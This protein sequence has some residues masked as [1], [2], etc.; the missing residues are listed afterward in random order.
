MKKVI[1]ILMLFLITATTFSQTRFG[2]GIKLYNASEITDFRYNY[3]LIPV[4]RTDGFLNRYIHSDSLVLKSD[5]LDLRKTYEAGDGITIINDTINNDNYFQFFQKN[6]PSPAFGSVEFGIGTTGNESTIGISRTIGGLPRFNLK[7]ITVINGVNTENLIL[8]NLNISSANVTSPK[9]VTFQDKAGVIALT[10]DI[11]TYQA[12]ANITIDNPNSQQPIINSLGGSSSFQDVFDVNGEVSSGNSLFSIEGLKNTSNPFININVG[13][14]SQ[15]TTTNSITDRTV[16]FE[17]SNSSTNILNRFELGLNSDIKLSYI[18]SSTANPIITSLEVKDEN[19]DLKTN[20]LLASDLDISEIT[21]PKSLITK[22][23]AD[24]N[25]SGGGSSS[26]TNLS[27]TASA[28]QGEVVSSDGT[29]A[30]IPV[31]TTTNAGLQKA[32]FYEEGTFTPNLNHVYAGSSFT[33]T[34]SVAKYYRVGNI[35]SFELV[36]TGINTTG[37]PNSNSQIRLNGL[38]FVSKNIRGFPL[39]VMKGIST[40][41]KDYSFFTQYNTNYALLYFGG[42]RPDSSYD[43]VSEVRGASI[44][45][46]KIYV[47]GSYITNVYTP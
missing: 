14:N 32:N 41:Q 9:A 26:I 20:E 25:Y 29:N 38:P 7:N 17:Y 11:K 37:T 39:F 47:S 21:N 23:Y 30:I 6:Y 35:V 8:K 22:E 46:G 5:L 36:L 13:G 1:A 43:N 33:Y 2:R 15:F 3:N 4:M 12:G 28:T 42:T 19:I 27:Y 34:V 10:S 44:T 40:T 45:N 16:S 31:A 24:A 18:N